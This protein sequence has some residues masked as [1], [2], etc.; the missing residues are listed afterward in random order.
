MPVIIVTVGG[1]LSWRGERRFV[2]SVGR[3]VNSIG[4][5]FGGLFWLR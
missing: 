3:W 1:L 5:I 4:A 2:V